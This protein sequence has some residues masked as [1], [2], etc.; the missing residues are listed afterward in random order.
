ME[1][2]EPRSSSAFI[3]L[4][5]GLVLVVV[6]LALLVFVLP[7]A[8]DPRPRKPMDGVTYRTTYWDKWRFDRKAR[9]ITE[10]YRRA[11]RDDAQEVGPL[12]KNDAR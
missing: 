3:P 9:Q 4:L 12:K 11:L 10:E 5:S 6:T 1:G 7:I 2:R 8:P